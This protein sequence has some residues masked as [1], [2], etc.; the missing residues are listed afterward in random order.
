MRHI[1]DSLD[2]ISDAAQSGQ[3][4]NGDKT[5][6]FNDLIIDFKNTWN[7]VVLCTILYVY[8]KKW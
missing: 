3:C 2:S 4:D 5:Q 8:Y 7:M 6:L 1:W